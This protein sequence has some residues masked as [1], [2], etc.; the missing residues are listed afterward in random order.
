MCRP[1]KHSSGGVTDGQTDRRRTKWSLC[2][3]MLRRRHKKRT[4]PWSLLQYVQVSLTQTSLSRFVFE[5]K[6][7]PETI[8]IMTNGGITVTETICLY[9]LYPRFPGFMKTNYDCHNLFPIGAIILELTVLI[10]YQ[11]VRRYVMHVSLGKWKY[12]LKTIT[13][14][15]VV[16]VTISRQRAARLILKVPNVWRVWGVIICCNNIKYPYNCHPMS[17]FV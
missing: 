8:K 16:S 2:V 11:W 1:A 12:C 15:T 9:F 3:A 7:T 10:I 14:E 6:M 17:K 5:K 13:T 4:W